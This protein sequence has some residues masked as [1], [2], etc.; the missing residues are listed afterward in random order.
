MIVQSVRGDDEALCQITLTT[1][2]WKTNCR[3]SRIKV[4][5]EKLVSKKSTT[6]V[7]IVLEVLIAVVQSI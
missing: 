7:L 5:W 6:K 1:H 3:R 4:T 2:Y